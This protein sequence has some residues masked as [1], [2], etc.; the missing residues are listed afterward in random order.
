MPLP[1]RNGAGQVES[2][3]PLPLGPRASRRMRR[4]GPFNG[5]GLGHRRIARSP[6]AA[7]T[8]AI[9]RAIVEYD[10]R[11][12]ASAAAAP[13]ASAVSPEIGAASTPLSRPYE[14]APQRSL[15]A[16]AW[17]RVS[18]PRIAPARIAVMRIAAGP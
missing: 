5:R 17:T 13:G 11:P 4:A 7:Q 18:A 12:A 3:L 8:P 9:R 16:E 15:T 1:L 6:P 2:T 10:P 14:S